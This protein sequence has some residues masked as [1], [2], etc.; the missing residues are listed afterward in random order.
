[1]IQRFTEIRVQTKGQGLYEITNEVI[2]ECSR[3]GVL[4]GLINLSIL[5]TSAS[6]LIQEN[7]DDDVLADLHRYFNGLVPREAEYRHKS[8][9]D[10]DMPAHIRSALTNTNLSVSI[11]GYKPVLGKWQ[12]LFVFEHRDR[13]HARKIMCHILGQSEDRQA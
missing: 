1:M 3:A 13:P 4:N 9:G 12:G 5:H 6:M 8:E 10:D 2:T 7:A 11:Q